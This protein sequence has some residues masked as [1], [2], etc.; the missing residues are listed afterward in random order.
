[1]AGWSTCPRQGG[2]SAPFS[3]TA[4]HP[5]GGHMSPVHGFHYLASA[6]QGFT[7]T[8]C[9]VLGAGRR[10]G[11]A[12]QPRPPNPGVC[13]ANRRSGGSRDPPHSPP[14]AWP[15]TG[16]SDITRNRRRRGRPGAGPR[17]GGR[18]R[19]TPS[20]APTGERGPGPVPRAGG[21]GGAGGGARGGAGGGRAGG[22][23]GDPGAA[24]GNPAGF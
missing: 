14:G 16:E 19:R 6:T 10:R 2:A 17:A 15:R 12:G 4:T 21:P 23:Q 1:M 11:E 20:A 8:G 18:G 7:Q 3:S 22:A 9:R 24:P 5:E 13:L